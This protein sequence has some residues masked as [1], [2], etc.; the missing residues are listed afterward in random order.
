MKIIHT[1]EIFIRPCYFTL[2]LNYEIHT[3]YK[4]ITNDSSKSSLSQ[5]RFVWNVKNY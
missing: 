5:K 1:P 3:Y 2:K 4:T